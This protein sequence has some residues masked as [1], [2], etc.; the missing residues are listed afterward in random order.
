MA[1][2]KRYLLV[3]AALL[4]VISLSIGSL[5]GARAW[6]ASE[7]PQRQ[8]EAGAGGGTTEAPAEAQTA[9]NPEVREKEK[10][11]GELSAPEILSGVQVIAHGMGTVDGLA[12][13]NCLEGFQIGRASCRER[14]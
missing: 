5:C 2:K 13:L 7:K 12:T 4:A 3:T 1:K 11:E 6:T 8:A 14:V 10:P 9:E